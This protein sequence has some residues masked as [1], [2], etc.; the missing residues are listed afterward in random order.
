M[1]CTRRI[2]MNGISEFFLWF[3]TTAYDYIVLGVEG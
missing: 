3:W 1:V 2:E